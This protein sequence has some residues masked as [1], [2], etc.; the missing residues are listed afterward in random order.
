[1][2]M[3]GETAASSAMPAS[4]APSARISSRCCERI[5]SRA[6][7]CHCARGEDAYSLA[8]V[9]YEEGLLGKSMIYATDPSEAAVESA[10]TATRR[11]PR[12]T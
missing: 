12:I 9:L 6:F 3:S 7:G 1:M 2:A 11:S 5:R 8:T 4:S 10:K